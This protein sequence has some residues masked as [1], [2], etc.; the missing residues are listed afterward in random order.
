MIYLYDLVKEQLLLDTFYVSVVFNYALGPIVTFLKRA[1]ARKKPDEASGG[2]GST[3]KIAAGLI[4]VALSIMNG[5]FHFKGK[6]DVKRMTDNLNEA[7]EE[8]HNLEV[9]GISNED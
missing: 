6:R 4:H 5:Y 1:P 8:L 7:L 9:G 2:K 3:N